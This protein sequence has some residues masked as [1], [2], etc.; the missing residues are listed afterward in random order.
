MAYAI[1]RAILRRAEEWGRLDFAHDHPLHPLLMATPESVDMLDL[2][3]IERPPLAELTGDD[4]A[5]L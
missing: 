5:A 1:A 3:E 2:E 4:A